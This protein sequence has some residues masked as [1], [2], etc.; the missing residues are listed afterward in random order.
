M[1]FRYVFLTWLRKKYFIMQ[2]LEQVKARRRKWPTT[3]AASRAPMCGK[4]ARAR[5]L[6]HARTHKHTHTPH[7]IFAR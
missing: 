1:Y 4:R 5:A 2:F 3:T 7:H 6:T